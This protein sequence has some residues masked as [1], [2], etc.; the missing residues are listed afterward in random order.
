MAT[1]GPRRSTRVRTQVK[2][3]AVKQAEE[4]DGKRKRKLDPTDADVDT[5]K[6]AKKN[7]KTAKSTDA[8]GVAS[9]SAP[10]R[11]QSNSSWHGDAAERRIAV[12]NRNVPRLAPGQKETRLRR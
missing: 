5:E 4:H 12:K 8:E 1:E 9:S 6:P 7:K 2:S 10:M 11:T 3:Y